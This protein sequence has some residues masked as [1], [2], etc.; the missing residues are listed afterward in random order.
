MQ[1]NTETR[2]ALETHIFT[3]SEE[4][5]S[6]L[7]SKFWL[8]KTDE[9]ENNGVLPINEINQQF[10]EALLAAYKSNS[11]LHLT[12]DERIQLVKYAF[13][14]SEKLT[15]QEEL[16]ICIQNMQVHAK[17]IRTNSC[18]L[19]SAKAYTLVGRAKELRPK[20]KHRN[21]A[22]CSYFRAALLGDEEA[23]ERFIAF[24][25]DEN[26]QIPNKFKVAMNQLAINKYHPDNIKLLRTVIHL[27]DVLI[28]DGKAKPHSKIVEDLKCALAQALILQPL[29]SPSAYNKKAA[30]MAADILNEIKNEELREE[31]EIHFEEFDITLPVK[32]AAPK[33][34]NKR[35]RGKKRQAHKNAKRNMKKAEL[36][37]AQKTELAQEDVFIASNEEN[38]T[39]EDHEEKEEEKEQLPEPPKLISMPFSSHPF[40]VVYQIELPHTIESVLSA[41][42]GSFLVGSQVRKRVLYKENHVKNI[43][44]LMS[45]VDYD[46][47]VQGTPPLESFIYYAGHEFVRN[48]FLPNLYHN[49][50]FNIDIYFSDADS[51]VADAKRRCF[52]VNALYADAKG[53]VFEPL[54][55]G[56]NHLLEKEV[57]TILTDLEDDLISFKNNPYRIFR[58]IALLSDG[59][60]ENYTIEH[61]SENNLYDH[62]DGLKVTNGMLYHSLGKLFTHGKAVNNLLLL[63]RFGLLDKLFPNIKGDN[64]YNLLIELAKTDNLYHHQPWKQLS[65]THIFKQFLIA[66]MRDKIT[67]FELMS[68]TMNKLRFPEDLQAG[69]RKTMNTFCPFSPCLAG[70][71]SLYF[72]PEPP[73]LN[74][75]THYPPCKFF[76]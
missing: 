68:S 41:I 50:A 3:K 31:I 44:S 15:S 6:D 13:L 52:T 71:R 16:V 48:A 10:I 25:N 51:L 45:K 47:V 70:N 53:N 42:P 14:L 74:G 12:I 55:C 1:R 27:L 43:E 38:K 56:I 37:L 60:Q 57:H 63:D 40:K 26:A 46:I 49:A 75:V 11:P 36:E 24:F 33:K 4:R 69:I 76:I 17:D 19:L 9:S 18:P 66:E 61:F 64:Y 8:L 7:T 67:D 5:P 21:M 58:Y 22:L 32:Q 65:K 28:H 73:P 35:K 2:K 72:Q 23:K 20:A 30:L 54:D 34:G 62:L 39:I 29:N 59:Y